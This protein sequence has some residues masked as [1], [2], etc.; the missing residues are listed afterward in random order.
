MTAFDDKKQVEFARAYATLMDEARARLDAIPIIH[1]ALGPFVPTYVV[2]ESAYTQLRMVCEIIAIGC[3]VA[4]GDIPATRD[5]GGGIRGRQGFGS[6]RAPI[7]PPPVAPTK[8]T[9]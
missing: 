5:Y 6:I 8:T 3:L 2:D 9:I 1:S 4:H 7:S